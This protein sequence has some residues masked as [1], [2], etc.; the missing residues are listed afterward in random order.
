VPKNR[1]RKRVQRTYGWVLR[2]PWRR[3]ALGRLSERGFKGIGYMEQ[4]ARDARERRRAALETGFAP[5]PLTIEL[6]ADDEGYVPTTITS[7]IKR[8]R[9]DLFGKDLSDSAIYRR[10]ARL[11]ELDETRPRTCAIEECGNDLPRGARS[12]RRYCAIHATP[13]ERVRRHR[14]SDR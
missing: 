8:A 4:L 2:V 6:L 14:R 5:P 1:G 13:V 11:R 9:I 7:A 3:P 12:T 10:L